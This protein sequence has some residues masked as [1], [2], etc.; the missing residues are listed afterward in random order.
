[1]G[2]LTESITNRAACETFFPGAWHAH[3]ARDFTGE[4]PVPLLFC[5]EIFI[6][7]ATAVCYKL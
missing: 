2:N 1:M 6:E 3:P 7:A 5:L 4:T